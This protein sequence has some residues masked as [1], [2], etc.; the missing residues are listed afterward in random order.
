MVAFRADVQQ[1]LTFGYARV[2]NSSVALENL[3]RAQGVCALDAGDRVG[4]Y[5]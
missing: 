2:R 3:A 5:A 1:A 4:K